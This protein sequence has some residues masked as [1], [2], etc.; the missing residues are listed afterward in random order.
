[1]DKCIRETNAFY[2]INVYYTDTDTLYIEKKYWDVLDKAG[3][4]GDGLCLGKNE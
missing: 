4:V 3:L 1:M 2:N